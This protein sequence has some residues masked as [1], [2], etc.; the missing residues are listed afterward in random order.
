[1]DYN[2]KKVMMTVIYR[3]PSQNKNE[4]EPFLSN[5]QKILNEVH[6]NKPLSGNHR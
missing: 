2:N 1:M 4:F 6:N 3:S 5:F